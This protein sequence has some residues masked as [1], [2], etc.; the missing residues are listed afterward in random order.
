[1]VRYD[2]TD[3][4]LGTTLRSSL[5]SNIAGSCSV[6]SKGITSLSHRFERNI[7][8]AGDLLIV[9]PRKVQ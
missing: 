5:L 7:D 4:S 1:M 3:Y 6:A 2:V 8:H 9:P